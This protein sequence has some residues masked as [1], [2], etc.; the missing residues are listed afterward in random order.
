MNNPFKQKEISLSSGYYFDIKKKIIVYL[1]VDTQSEDFG[2][3]N[4]YSRESSERSKMSFELLL[5]G[6]MKS[7]D[8]N[9]LHSLEVLEDMSLNKSLVQDFDWIC[10]DENVKESFVTFLNNNELYNLLHLFQQYLNP[11]KEE[12]KVEIVIKDSWSSY[13]KYK[14]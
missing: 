8:P 4:L 13:P 10:K 3:Q 14:K 12:K 6:R 7:S 9:D 2:R 5:S 1:D 11:V